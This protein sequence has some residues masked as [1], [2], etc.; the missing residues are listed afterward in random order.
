MADRDGLI[1]QCKK[2]A[3][4]FG[5][6]TLWRMNLSHSMLTDWG[7]GHVAVEP[8]YTILEVGCGGGRTISKLARMASAG[9]VC[10][11]D[12]SDESVA[13]SRRTNAE[14]I[15]S[16]RV[17]IRSGSVS[18]LPFPDATF[19]LITAVETHFFWPDLPGDMREVYR[20]LKPDGR[21]I[22]IA[23][24]YK[25]ARTAAARLAEKHIDRMGMTLLTVEEHRELLAGAGLADVRVIEQ[26][27]KGWICAVGSKPAAA[28]A[29]ITR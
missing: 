17:E 18:R 2:P 10:G 29:Q 9:K 23:E 3:G 12:Y 22:L 28:A 7:L 24:I 6:L 8:H 14:E 16:G 20:V 5:R 13:A 26:A 11:I 21:F 19:D 4:W 27:D 25:G 1:N 15:R